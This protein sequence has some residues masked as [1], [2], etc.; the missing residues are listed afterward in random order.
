MRPTIVAAVSA[1]LAGFALSTAPLAQA[2]PVPIE[3]AS[4]AQKGVALKQFKLAVDLFKADKYEQ[5]LK[6]FNMSFDKVASPNT[7]LMIARTLTKLERYPEAYEQLELAR[8]ES[9]AL[10]PGKSK[11]RDT[12]SAATV[13]LEAL[14]D[15]VVFIEVDTGS[16][17]LLDDKPVEVERWG[18]KL[19]R[20]PGKFTLELKLKNGQRKKVTLELGPG[21]T[22]KADLSVPAPELSTA[23]PPA[24][25]LTAKPS[26]VVVQGV[27]Y[28]ALAWTGVGVAA[29]GAV[30]FTVFGL[31]GADRFQTLENECP[32]QQ[33]PERLRDTAEQGRTFQTLANVSLGVG[34]TGLIGAT[35]FV[36]V[37]SRAGNVTEERAGAA[38]SAAERSAS[39]SGAVASLVESTRV[40]LGPS[41]V[42]VIGRF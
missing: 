39:S 24:S 41:S 6:M 14:E 32:G 8:V 33:C 3:V 34:I 13:A 19:V 20:M 18:R 23:P 25:A 27:S 7:R 2:Q 40:Y 4:A 12:A 10:A 5:A 28:G 37:N 9:E 21:Q 36:L 16:E 29:A 11:Y 35:V 38:P 31:T 22:A 42:T 26:P 17:L 15:K 30:G 1:V